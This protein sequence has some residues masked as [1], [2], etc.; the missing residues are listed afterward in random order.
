M[1]LLDILI[2]KGTIPVQDPL[3][4]RSPTGDFWRLADVDPDPV[5]LLGLSGVYVIWHGGV[6]PQWLRAGRAQNLGLVLAEARVDG[7]LRAWE[8]RGGLF[9]TWA[10]VR[11]EFQDPVVS[12]LI[13]TLN[14]LLP[15]PRCSD[16][17]EPLPVLLPGMAAPG[18]RPPR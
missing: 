11:A 2:G 3:W 18:G 14:P 4:V 13:R 8:D 9:V 16:F 15:D 10:A 12:Y 5:G 7:P 1:G 17:A 6:Q